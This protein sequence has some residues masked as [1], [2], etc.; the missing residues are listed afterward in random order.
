MKI[1]LY[2]L[3]ARCNTALDAIA[4]WFTIFILSAGCELGRAKDFIQ[5]RARTRTICAW[6]HRTIHPRWCFWKQDTGHNVSHGICPRCM[7]KHFY[8]GPDGRSAARPQ[9][10]SGFQPEDP[11]GSAGLKHR[12]TL[13][14]RASG[15]QPEDQTGLNPLKTF[16]PPA[17]SKTSDL[18]GLA[19]LSSARRENS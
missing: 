11:N 10:A 17:V 2:R 6:C 4:E 15:V 12:S 9:R 8:L 13:Q 7:A 16:P 1:T 5:W 14:E 18:H 3:N 19:N